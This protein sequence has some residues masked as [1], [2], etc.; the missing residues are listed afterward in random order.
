MQRNLSRANKNTLERIIFDYDR[1]LPMTIRERILVQEINRLE[2]VIGIG[3]THDKDKEKDKDL[4][5][6]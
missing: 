4:S 6:D 2:D 3:K 5:E 1:H